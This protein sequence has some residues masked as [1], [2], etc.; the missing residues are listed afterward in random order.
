MA[1]RG[2]KREAIRA[3]WAATLSMVVAGCGVSAGVPRGTGTA[4]LVNET[5]SGGGNFGVALTDPAL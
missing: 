1:R 4:A 3:P 2:S 5:D